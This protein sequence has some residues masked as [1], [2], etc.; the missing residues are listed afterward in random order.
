M[1]KTYRLLLMGMLIAMTL[2][3]LSCDSET[4]SD[5]LANQHLTT[6]GTR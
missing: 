6:T 4:H 2:G 3:L 1:H 5:N